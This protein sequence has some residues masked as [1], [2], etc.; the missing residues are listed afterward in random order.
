MEKAAPVGIQGY[1]AFYPG[2]A[3][4]LLREYKGLP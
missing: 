3:V 4:K 2:D 1:V